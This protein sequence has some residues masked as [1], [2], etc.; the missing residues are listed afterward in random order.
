[1]QAF[2]SMVTES[3]EQNAVNASVFITQIPWPAWST[4]MKQ[5]AGVSLVN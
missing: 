2:I 3:E 4:K 5:K 1:M